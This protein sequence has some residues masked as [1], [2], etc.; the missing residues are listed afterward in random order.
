MNNTDEIV[1]KIN[2]LELKTFK[3]VE[4]ISCN[5]DPH[6]Y[7]ITSSHL[8]KST[9]IYLDIA[10]AERNGAHCGHKNEKGRVD[11][12]LPYDQHTCQHALILKPSYDIIKAAEENGGKLPDSENQELVLIKNCI[13]ENKFDID[14][15][16]FAKP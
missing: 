9:G 14:L 16:G 15:L 6:P 2:R 11:C 5:F 7:V 10:E 4:A 13:L 1:E 8:A 3:A 12:W